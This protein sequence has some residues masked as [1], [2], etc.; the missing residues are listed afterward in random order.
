MWVFGYGSLMWDGWEARFGGR[1]CG[2]AVLGGYERVLDK[3]SVSNWGT[4]EQ[5]C[6]TLRVVP[7]AR[8]C[9]GCAFELPENE[10]DAAMA[11]L[12]HREGSAFELTQCSVVLEAGTEIEAFV[13]LP[14]GGHLPAWPL[15]DR[16]ALVPVAR[17]TS[18]RCCDYLRQLRSKLQLLGITD[19]A[20]EELWSAV[21]EQP[22]SSCSGRARR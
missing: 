1:P 16:A 2:L 8:D 22:G 19:R 10:A 6:P 7:S 18:G 12:K 5:P 20:V 15:Q 17:G 3:P 9:L 13:P 21:Q 14:A 11:Y 4:H